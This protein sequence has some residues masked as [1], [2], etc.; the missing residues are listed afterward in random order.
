MVGVL[1]AG[2]TI[3]LGFNAGGFFPGATATVA[4]VVCFGMVIGVMLV[5]RPFE[6]F[7]P[8]LLVPL[9]LLAAFAIWTLLS[10]VWSDAAGR[11]LLEFDRA[12]LYVLVFGFFGMLIPGKRRLEWGLRGFAAAALVVCVAGW[13][14]R[15]AADVWPIALDVQPERL[16]FPLTYWN[17]LGLLAA[18]GTI[19]CAHLSSSR[20]EPRAV[21]VIAA[22]AI[23]LLS[24]ALLL[25]YSRAA[26]LLVPIALVAYALIA[27][28]KRLVA[29]VAATILP[30]IV[31]LAASYRADDVS[32]AAF[33][34]PAGVSQGHDLAMIVI[35]CVAV[36]GLTRWLF[37]LN[38]DRRLDEW[39]PPRLERR[40][41]ALW[42]GGSALAVIVV[43]VALGAPSW[44]GD[45]YDRFVEG[46][47]VGHHDDPRGRLTSAGNNGRIPQWEAALDDFRAEPLHGRGGRHLPAGLGPGAALRVHRDRRPLALHRGPRRARPGRLP[48]DRRRDRRDRLRPG[49]PPR[50][51]RTPGLRRRPGSA[52]RLGVHAGVDWDWE[53]PVV[54]LW[55]FALAGLALSKPIADKAPFFAAG[56][57]P[58]RLVRI[59][60]AICVGVL[61]ITPAAIGLSQSKLD[62]AVAD[63]KRGDCTAAID[64]SLDALDA[65]KI[66]PQ[67]Y[68]LIG[69]CDSRLGQPQLAIAAMENAVDRDPKSW[70]THYGL[71]LTQALAGIDPMPELREAQSLNPL[72][73]AVLET[74]EAMRDASPRERERRATEARLPI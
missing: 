38:L 46:D 74:I 27:R 40:K 16:S 24:S 19:A 73:P 35:A 14:T 53:M 71:A 57:E 8:G 66:R 29:T 50:G 13:I 22:G 5:T 55:L 58:G 48:A 23:P 49:S 1:I 26:L 45:Q 4:I 21:R 72:E 68:E 9:A 37:G 39:R 54:T 6:S 20:R 11:A 62:T 17:A 15:V 32:S 25:T 52:R 3:F 51:R 60:A 59:V 67:P 18:L 10:A 61:S 34:S 64:S 70:E 42:G 47:S 28:P 56:Y 12:L 41:V 63:F 36:A 33:A 44:A 69:Y 31:A 65:L 2:M 43:A 30:V 7:T